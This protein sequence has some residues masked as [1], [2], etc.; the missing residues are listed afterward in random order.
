ML[1]TIQLY[2]AQNTISGI[3][4]SLLLVYFGGVL[5]S[6]TPCIFPMIPIT[7]SILGKHSSHSKLSIHT[8]L[9][10]YGLGVSTAFVSLGIIAV[11]TNSMFGSVTQNIWFKIIIANIFIGIGL[12]TLGALR[13]PTFHMNTQ[14]NGSKLS[15]FSMGIAAGLS[16]S[17]CTLPVL[18]IVLQ[19]ASKT[20]LL[21]GSLLLWSYAWGFMTLLLLVSIL[22]QNVMSRILKKRKFLKVMDWLLT[23]ICFGVAEWILLNA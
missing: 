9:L 20:S 17:P 7:F 14:A 5:T 22:G 19:Y 11:A 3:I 12:N 6:L 13:L 21:I 23:I 10:L 18:A 15:I 16:L 8:N 2:L 4:F 1:D